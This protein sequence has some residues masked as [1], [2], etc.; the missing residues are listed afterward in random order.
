MID[1]FKGN[2]VSKRDALKVLYTSLVPIFYSSEIVPFFMEQIDKMSDHE[3]DLEWTGFSDG[4]LQKIMMV[5]SGAG[6][7]ELREEFGHYLG[8]VR[9]KYF[10][11]EYDKKGIE[12]V[13]AEVKAKLNEFCNDNVLRLN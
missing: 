9:E 7:E 8:E 2:L 5:F 3:V 11:G 13:H 1:F 12:A 10:N 6:S 4:T